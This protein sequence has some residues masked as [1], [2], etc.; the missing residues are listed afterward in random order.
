MLIVEHW[1]PVAAFSAQRIS[2]H[3]EIPN[4]SFRT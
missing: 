4:G 1:L 3:G 2:T